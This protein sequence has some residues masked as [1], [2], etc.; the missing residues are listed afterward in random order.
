[1]NKILIFLEGN[2]RGLHPVG[3]ELISEVIT[4]TKDMNDV[5]VDALYVGSHLSDDGVLKV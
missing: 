3:L 2:A 1:M 4:Q 5:T